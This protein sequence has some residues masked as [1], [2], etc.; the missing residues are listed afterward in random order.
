[1]TNA[2]VSS[3]KIKNKQLLVLPLVAGGLILISGRVIAGPDLVV[4]VP[5]PSVSVNVDVDA[6][7]DFYT[8]DGYE[9]VGIVGDQC[10]YLGPG[11]VWLIC[12]PVRFAR[13]NDFERVHPD[14]R[15]HLVTNERYRND[16]H[17]HAHPRGE[18]AQLRD[19]RQVDRINDIQQRRENQINDTQQRREN[20]INDT[21]QRR[22]NQI[23][24]A[25]QKKEAHQAEQNAK[26]DKSQDS[27]H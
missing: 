4:T 24:D 15:T 8:W 1:M 23:N 22:E 19:T 11:N 27:G 5:V 2:E 18:K 17:G 9:Y 10:Y 25:Q 20:Q 21:Q 3:M 13:F 16:A 7:P 12:D 14:W 6:V 26:K